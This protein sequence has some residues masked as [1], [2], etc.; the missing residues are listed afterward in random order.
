MAWDPGANFG[1]WNGWMRE[2]GVSSTRVYL[3]YGM[4]ALGEYTYEIGRFWKCNFFWLRPGA[5]GFFIYLVFPFLC[6]EVDEY[7]AASPGRLILIA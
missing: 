4:I 7:E 2:P 6:G 1:L 3:G 5:S